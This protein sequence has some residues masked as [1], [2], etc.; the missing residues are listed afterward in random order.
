VS[1]FLIAPK[2]GRFYLS[3]TRLVEIFVT[4]LWKTVKIVT[5][6]VTMTKVDS[7]SASMTY[8]SASVLDRGPDRRLIVLFPASASDDPNVSRQIWKIASSCGL[9]VL[10]ISLCNEYAEE[11]QLRRKLVTMAAVIKDAIVSTDIMIERGSDWLG[12]VKNVW[13]PGDL[14]ACYGGQK[15]GLMRRALDKELSS[16]LDAPLYILVEEKPAEKTRPNVLLQA[17]PWVGSFAIIA[18]FLLAEM[19]IVRLPQNW[20]HNV[21]LYMCLFLE[22]GLLWG[23]NSLFM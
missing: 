2:T 22:A 19:Q 4:I 17:L 21:L 14:I 20:T 3:F 23:W 18:G 7:L 13:R 16:R 8:P 1:F 11:A 9:D 15:V 10:F 5:I 12:K 6:E